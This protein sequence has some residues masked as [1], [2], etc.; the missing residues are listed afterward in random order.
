MPVNE[1]NL[2]TFC[3][4]Q[5]DDGNLRRRTCAEW[6]VLLQHVVYADAKA[7]EVQYGLPISV[8]GLAVAAQHNPLDQIAAYCNSWKSHGYGEPDMDEQG[9]HPPLPAHPDLPR[10]RHDRPL[11]RVRMT[12]H[13]KSAVARCFQEA[14][15][16]R[17]HR[18]GL[19]DHRST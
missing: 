7:A 8:I 10:R 14:D 5:T 16:D 18:G 19:Q 9:F 15:R 1:L 2:T 4:A 17:L 11:L 3:D 12:P 6:A 13:I